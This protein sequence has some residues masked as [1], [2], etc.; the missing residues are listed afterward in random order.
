MRLLKVLL[1]GLVFAAIGPTA[2]AAK[3]AEPRAIVSFTTSEAPGTL[4]VD[5][6]SHRLYLVL[7]GGKAIRYPV[8]VGKEAFA[9]RGT[10]HIARRAEWPAWYPPKEMID[11]AA[12][13]SQFLPYSFEGGRLNPLGA[14]ALYLYQGSRD[15]LYRIH[16]TNEPRT[17]GLSVS[18]GCIRMLND[19]VI[20]LYGRVG[21]GTKVVVR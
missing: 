14:R 6:A 15:T 20:D 17:I 1:A 3:R 4:I 12:A 7:G 11:R 9:W 2:E 13:R 5:T 18:S 16:G 19:D 10:A 8:G 21:I